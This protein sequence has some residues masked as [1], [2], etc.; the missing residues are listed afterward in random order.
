MVTLHHQNAVAASED[1]GYRSID[2]VPAGAR[3]ATVFPNITRNYF[4]SI[5]RDVTLVPISGAA[6]IAPHLG[7][8]DIIVDLVSTGSTLKVNGL[9]EV[10]TILTSAAQLIAR[11]DLMADPQNERRARELTAALES[12]LRAQDQRYLMA[13]VPRAMLP[14]I[15]KILPQAK[16]V[17]SKNPH[18][19]E[20]VVEEVEIMAGWLP[21]GLVALPRSSTLGTSGRIVLRPSGT[22]P[23]I[24]VMVEGSDEKLVR[25]ICREL[26]KAVAAAAERKVAAVIS[27][28]SVSAI[29]RSSAVSA[30]MSAI[31]ASNAAPPARPSLRWTKSAAWMP[32]VPS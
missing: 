21:P 26:A 29:S 5:G 28:E 7:V 15:K 3:V 14:Q 18:E 17:I 4:A 22:E 27:T 23:V 11:V 20:E 25:E 12:V 13:N 2:D 1:S 8:A 16:L 31:R 10:Q 30:R 19:I 32:L 6:E 9:V 24:R